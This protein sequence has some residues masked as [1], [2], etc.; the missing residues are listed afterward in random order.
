MRN[1]AFIVCMMITC[2]LKA[3]PVPPTTSVQF[4]SVGDDEFPK[5][6][7][8]ACEPDYKEDSDVAPRCSDYMDAPTKTGRKG[9]TIMTVMGKEKSLDVEIIYKGIV[10]ATLKDVTANSVIRGMEG[11]VRYLQAPTETEVSW[12][13]RKINRS[14]FARPK[15][16]Q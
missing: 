9:R 5:Y 4:E 10:V 13:L 11:Y 6:K 1:I 12:D 7:L 16:G 14:P 2:G 8:L 15:T 3:A